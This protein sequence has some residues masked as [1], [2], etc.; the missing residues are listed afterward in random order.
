[1][2]SKMLRASLVAVAL[3]LAGCNASLEDIAPKAAEKELPQRIVAAMQAKGMS[4]NAPIMMRIFKE[5]GVLEVWKQ[6]TNGRYDLVTTY[7]ICKWSGKLGPKFREGDRQAP[8]GFYSVRP[9]QMNPNSS[10]H[11]AF[12]MGFPNAFDAA[13]GRNGRHLMVHGACSSSGCYS[14]TDPQMEE[15]YAFARDAFRGGQ[16]E[17]QVQ[18]FPFRMTPE[19]MAR[20]RDDPNFQFWKMLKEGYDHFELSK[21]P[22]K[23]D[24]CERRYVFNHFPE[25][26][27]GFTP[28]G[29]CP[30][31]SQPE[32]LVTAYKTYQSSYQAAFSMAVAERIKPPSPSIAGHKEA[33]LVAEWS[34]KRARG[35][36]VSLDP[37]SMLHDGTVVATTTRTGRL[38]SAV[39][40]ER[41]AAER[42]GVRAVPATTASV[43]PAAM[44]APAQPPAAAPVPQQQ[45]PAAVAEESAEAAPAATAP[46]AAEA[47]PPSRLRR[48]WNMLGG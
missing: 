15:I 43:T 2:N 12:N 47:P 31:A 20:Y 34:R 19:N 35:E 42:N 5:E 46:A 6:K 41:R 10:Y 32:S 38:A 28:A 13:N 37:P 21:V 26:G 16:T 17:F 3:A 30:P 48:I 39:E 45:Q 14:M 25:N 36:R 9:A 27:R 1:M 29:A 18:A 8:E 24:V 11:L 33:T 7:D 40:A 22:P 23:V 4:R 44:R